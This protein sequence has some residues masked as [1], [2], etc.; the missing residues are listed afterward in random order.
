MKLG[1]PIA[2]GNTAILYSYGEYVCKVFHDHHS[3]DEAAREANKQHQVYEAGLP[4]PKIIDVTQIDGKQA[5]IMERVKGKTLGSLLLEDKSRA[6]DYLSLSVD[7]QLQIH[8]KKIPSFER[9]TE[10][11]E[12]QILRAAQVDTQQKKQLVDTL[13]SI[14]NDEYLCHGDYHLFNLLLTDHGITIIDWVDASIGDRM[15]DVYRTYLL[16]SQ[17]SHEIAELYVH[18]YCQKRGCDKAELFK[19]APIVAAA[20]LSENVSTENPERLLRI[21]K[22][23]SEEK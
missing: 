1:S 3:K 7:V 23:A 6:Q 4:V 8:E 17:I 5:I 16:Y 10:K 20:R 19:W 15:A 14:S 12:H 18:L 21:V 2:T 22:K 11:L 13:K 9:M